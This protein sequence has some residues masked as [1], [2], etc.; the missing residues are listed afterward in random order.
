MKLNKKTCKDCGGEKYIFSKG[1]CKQC[2]NKT[3]KKL[4][5][6]IKPTGEKQLFIEIW[7]QRPHMC[8][9]C[10]TWLGNDPC[11]HFFSHIKSKK[12]HP[13]LRLVKTN[14]ELLCFDCHYER[15]HGTKEKFERR[16]NTHI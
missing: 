12:Q 8:I 2:A 1:R 16:K 4:T 9:N 14:I 11:A 6:K 5:N 3:Y 10:N 15:D 13:E 7:N